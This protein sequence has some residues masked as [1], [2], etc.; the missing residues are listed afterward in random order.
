MQALAFSFALLASVVVGLLTF[1]SVLISLLHVRIRWGKRFM[2][3]P[4][5][6]EDSPI[7]TRLFP[8]VIVI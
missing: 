8:G 3:F 4:L 5:L 1:L 7:L 6:S 2:L